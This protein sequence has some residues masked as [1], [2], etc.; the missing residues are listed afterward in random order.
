MILKRLTASGFKSFADKVRLEF[1][2]GIVAVVGPNGSGK[3]NIADAIRWVLGEQSKNLLRT[4][5]GEELVYAGTEGRSRAS[6]AEVTLLL[7]NSDRAVDL[8]FTEIEIS[9]KL[10]RDGESEYKL[11]GKIVRLSDVAQLLA[12][13]GFG[14]GSYTVIGQGMIDSFILATPAERKLLFEEASGIRQYELKREAARRQLS[15]TEA[16]LVRV[17]DITRELEPRLRELERSARAAAERRLLELEIADRRSS[18]IASAMQHFDLAASALTAE[19]AVLKDQIKVEKSEYTALEQRRREL[20]GAAKPAKTTGPSLDA[21][22]SSREELQAVVARM[23]AEL[24]HNRE[25]LDVVMK[26]P[27][28]TAH[29]EDMDKQL[30]QIESQLK[31]RHREEVAATARLESATQKVSAAQERLMALRADAEGS[32]RYEHVQHA[33]GLSR[34]LARKLAVERPT[35]QEVR[36]IVQKIGSMLILASDRTKS[37]LSRKLEV[38]SDSL[39][40]AMADRD[41]AHDHYTKVVIRARSLELDA[42]HWARQ[43]EQVEADTATGLKAL[44]TEK[45]RLNGLIATLELG[46]ANNQ[47]RLDA[48]QAEWH[49]KQQE[50]TNSSVDAQGIFEL[51]REL[52]Q[53][54]QRGRELTQQL[55]AKQI[56]F[57]DATRDHRRYQAEAKAWPVPL[58]EAK[59]DPLADQEKD[60]A[61]AEAK[62]S[63]VIT[64]DIDAEDEFVRVKDRHEF[65]T[66]QLADL[67]QA[68]ANLAKVINNIEAAIRERFA[69]AFSSLSTEFNHYFGV[70]FGG[71]KA[72]LKLDRDPD[73]SAYG[74]EISVTLPGKRL[75]NLSMLSGGERSMAGIALLAAI[76]KVNPSPFV[77]LDEVD[78]ALDE[79]NSLKLANILNEMAART[80]IIIITH[81]R[82]I[83]QSA[84]ILYGVSMAADG[85]SHVLSLKL[86]QAKATVKA[87]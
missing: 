19:I 9:R 47:T 49:A 52:E 53:A 34:E 82:Q 80:Q 77:V 21:L 61:L 87:V 50:Q 72:A 2:P 22:G 55:E 59:S 29:R 20:M 7:D 33:L 30:A 73:G 32:D 70:L 31:V 75:T 35:L 57:A 37:K 74:I 45:Q 11:G 8:D 40:Q 38:A 27:Q 68:S 42:S 79:A 13:A 54:E 41:E 44:D 12:A 26:A 56:A 1:E 64:D 65:L 5:K 10:F 6:V 60:L 14:V 83:M 84:G 86:E 39:T 85:A 62:L 17:R 58:G 15:E 48:A 66:S 18:Y 76:M 81:N 63:A 28:P 51:A 43:V 25:Q 16:N 3:S 23:G 78:A 69:V 67:E 4:K 46:L 71:G 24:E 36:I